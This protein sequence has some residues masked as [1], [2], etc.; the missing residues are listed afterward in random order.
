MKSLHPGACLFFVP[1]AIEMF[2]GQNYVSSITAGCPMAL[3]RT[4]AC[5]A[6]DSAGTSMAA[7]CRSKLMEIASRHALYILVAWKG[8]FALVISEECVVPPW[9]CLDKDL[10]TSCGSTESR[11]EWTRLPQGL[12][13]AKFVSNRW[14]D[15]TGT[16]GSPADMQSTAA[17][18]QGNIALKPYVRVAG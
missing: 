4:D 14:Q 9:D 1:V 17:V 16:D 5:I 3:V 15:N 6:G 18:R 2:I 13:C 8:G 11:T 7:C 10:L 12:V